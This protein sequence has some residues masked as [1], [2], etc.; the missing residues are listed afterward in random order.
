MLAGSMVYIIHKD[1]AIYKLLASTKNVD[2]SE[3][4]DTI[5]EP[6]ITAEATAVTVVVILTATKSALSTCAD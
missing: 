6:I 2:P 5:D 3:N 4:F 1:L